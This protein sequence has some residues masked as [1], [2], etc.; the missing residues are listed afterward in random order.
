[1]KTIYS[2]FKAG[3]DN[4]YNSFFISFLALK[5]LLERPLRKDFIIPIEGFSYN[6]L[7]AKQ[8]NNLGNSDANEYVNSIRRHALND[9][10]IC[11]ERYS[12]QMYASHI[13][14]QIRIDPAM[15][16]DRSINSSKFES[17]DNVYT[18]YSLKFFQQLKRLRNSIVH[19]N[20]VYTATNQLDYTFHKNEYHS[21]SHEG[22]L[23]SIELDTIM[24]I[25]KEV[26][27]LVKIINE[28]YFDNYKNNEDCK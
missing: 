26:D 21:D 5:P 17:L 28:R 13:N 24:F 19:F 6:V 7:E 12:T 9:I 14:K 4:I 10:V 18:E 22:E 1:M 15:L 11:Y 23:I 25:H 8:L 3:M 27:R 16:K 20:G 2:E